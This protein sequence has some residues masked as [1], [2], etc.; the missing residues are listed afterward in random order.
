MQPPG[1]GSGASLAGTTGKAP[2]PP[3]R[4]LGSAGVEGISLDEALVV[5]ISGVGVLVC[6]PTAVPHPTITT[7]RPALAR[8]AIADLF[9]LAIPAKC[10][11]PTRDAPTPSGTGRGGAK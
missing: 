7:N 8:S 1:S 10:R 4:S 2:P 9:L 3:V 11:R 5:G 6:A